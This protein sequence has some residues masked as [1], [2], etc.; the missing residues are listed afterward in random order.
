MHAEHGSSGFTIIEILVAVLVV[1][2]GLMALTGSSA[3]VARML[4]ASRRT[5]FATQ[6]A[7]RRLEQLRLT[8]RS[9]ASGCLALVPGMQTYPQGMTERWEIVPGPGAVMVRVV[10][11][12]PVGR[13]TSTDTVATAIACSR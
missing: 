8:A 9:S 2:V 7:E 10:T 11:T 3:A 12:W 6:T 13:G 4:G 5:S 1:G